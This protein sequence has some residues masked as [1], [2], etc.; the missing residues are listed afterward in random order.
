MTNL[1]LYARKEPTQDKTL[2][3]SAEVDGFKL[4]KTHYDVQ[5]YNSDKEPVVRYK[6]Y[7][8]SK[9]TRRNKYLMHNCFRYN[10]VW[11]DDLWPTP[12]QT[13]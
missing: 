2:L 5:I 7:H 6:W 4:D 12:R 3:D 10:L 8:G 11:L 13:G 1:T 9:P